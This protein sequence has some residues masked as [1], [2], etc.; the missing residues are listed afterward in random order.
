MRTINVCDNVNTSKGWAKILNQCLKAF[1]LLMHNLI[2]ATAIDICCIF[3]EDNRERESGNAESRAFL[4]DD[5]GD[6]KGLIKWPS[7]AVDKTHQ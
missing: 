3:R 1:I 2:P 7:P 4:V 5:L 6:E